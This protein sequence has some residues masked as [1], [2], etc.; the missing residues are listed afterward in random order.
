MMERDGWSEKREDTATNK[1]TN[2]FWLSGLYP[3]AFF[4]ISVFD[5]IIHRSFVVIDVFIYWF[6]D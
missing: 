6:Y 4:S 3:R 5:D 1:A 2:F